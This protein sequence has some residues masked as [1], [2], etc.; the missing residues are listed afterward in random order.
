M[1]TLTLHASRCDTTNIGFGSQSVA[2]ST[3]QRIE[4]HT[5]GIVQDTTIRVNAITGTA[6]TRAML[7]A[8]I[9]GDLL[10]HPA[11]DAEDVAGRLD[12]DLMEVAEIMDDLAYRG[13]LSLS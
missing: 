6:S 8:S 9:L 10:E 11:S 4:F 3:D 7:T 5:S 12:A 13:V 2:E 1:T